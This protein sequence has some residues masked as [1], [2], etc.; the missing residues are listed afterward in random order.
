MAL[1]RTARDSYKVWIKFNHC[2]L[3][4][5]LMGSSYASAGVSY[6]DLALPLSVPNPEPATPGDTFS[7][8]ISSGMSPASCSPEIAEWTR[9]VGPGNSVVLSGS[10]FSNYGGSSLGQDSA[11]WVYGQSNGGNGTL[12]PLSIQTLGQAR[13]RVILTLPASLPN[14]CYLIWP[15]NSAGLGAPVVVNQTDFWW[16]GPNVAAPSQTISAY[17][18]NFFYNNVTPEVYVG[19]LG[20]PFN[21]VNPVSWNPYKIDFQVPGALANGNYQVWVHNGH[22][23]HWGWSGP[24]TLTVANGFSWTGPAVSVTNT[25]FAGGADPSGTND[26][27]NAIEAAIVS[28]TA[29]AATNANATIN[30][31]AGNYQVSKDLIPPSNVRWLGAGMGSTTITARNNFKSS[32]LL[33]P[34]NPNSSNNIEIDDMGFAAGPT[35]AS[36]PYL[37]NNLPQTGSITNELIWLRALKNIHFNQVDFEAQGA[38]TFDC[39]SD[40]LVFFNNCTFLGGN[41]TSTTLYSVGPSQVFINGC[42]FYGTDDA[43][44]LIGI[45][46]VHGLSV[47]NCTGQ[48][49]NNS[50]TLSGLGWDQG[51]F[52]YGNTA[53]NSEREIYAGN[54]STF[55]LAI[56][57]GAPDTNAGEQ[58]LW[59]GNYTLASGNPEGASANTLILSSLS[60]VMNDAELG[61]W[62]AIVVAGP[63]LG[64]HRLITGYDGN[65]TITVS[66]PWQSIPQTS[67]Q[68]IVAEDLD[69]VVLYQNFI[70]GKSNY[71]TFVSS[72]LG[73]EPYGNSYDFIADGNNIQQVR[74]GINSYSRAETNRDDGSIEPCYFNM[75]LNNQ[76]NGSLVGA[77]S[78]ISDW[79]SSNT[80]YP[81]ILYF[82]NTFRNNTLDYS[83]NAGYQLSLGNIRSIPGT[84]IDMNIFE[85]NV[86]SNTPLAVNC[87]GSATATLL[88]PELGNTLFNSNQFNACTCSS[89]V[90]GSKGIDVGLG[91]TPE[92]Q[93]NSWNFFQTNYAGSVPGP[94]LEAPYRLSRVASFPNTGSLV[95][96]NS[97]TAPQTCSL[98]TQASWLSIVPAT[99]SIPNEGSFT[100]N[101][102]AAAV[103][104][105]TLFSGS[106]QAG[107]GSESLDLLVYYNPATAEAGL[108]YCPPKATSTPGH[109]DAG[110]GGSYI[111]PSPARGA[112]AKVAY[113][114][115]AAGHVEILVYNEAGRLIDKVEDNKSAGAQTSLLSTGEWAPGVYFYVCTLSPGNAP[116]QALP[117]VKF[118]VIH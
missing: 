30:F 106:I 24:Q 4:I 42:N 82:G 93:N 15:Q 18:R 10:Q 69:K 110:A 27:Y 44:G 50:S 9:F 8:P 40:T 67:S 99:G 1:H 29:L 77:A 32:C 22:G 61:Y 60:G 90:S 51:R 14:S 56:R 13:D 107:L 3:L 28:A 73:I 12:S 48:D 103:T 5:L 112:S 23:G 21:E 74:T 64:Q 85:T 63:G 117:M 46:A 41:N 111:Y 91:Q 59:E 19:P 58:Y 84:Q 98:T 101:Y 66:P 20:G 105:T 78:V 113:D 33:G 114:L 38:I 95:L 52:L 108:D 118:S 45:S 83:M 87:V 68:V 55:Q 25:A 97:G 6:P 37:T 16:L 75:Y 96:F 80:N 31:P 26:S 39:S 7:P 2:L 76:V 92:L 79:S 102:N 49:W 94:V 116:S 65:S 81:G 115:S 86:V 70:Q 53:Y 11:F 72:S 43:G 54:N 71:A 88:G 100:F 35:I 47:T 57:P 17:G 104:F 34:N 62:E 109:P 36:S 89:T